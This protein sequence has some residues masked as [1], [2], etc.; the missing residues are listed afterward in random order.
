[1]NKY[2]LLIIVIISISIPVNVGY[3]DANPV[4]IIKNSVTK[5][6]PKTRTSTRRRTKT[7]TYK[8]SK[9][10]NSNDGITGSSRSS[11]LA[12]N[13]PLRREKLVR[14]RMTNNEIALINSGKRVRYNGRD[15]VKRNNTFKPCQINNYGQT[16]LDLM[17]DAKAPYGIDG[18]S[19]E[20]HHLKQQNDG[21]IV[22]MTQ[23]EHRRSGD[24]SKDLH[25]YARNSSDVDHGSKWTSWKRNYWK[26]RASDFKG[27]KCRK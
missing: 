21:V 22:E 4:K 3:V 26:E 2:L 14:R 24:K 18:E 17:K 15:I 8:G 27:I 23:N 6:K 1:M 13:K 25:R 10:G 11:N 19:L 7:R 16:N 12:R 5:T 20:L 9:Y